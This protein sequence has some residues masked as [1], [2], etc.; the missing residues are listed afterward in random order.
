MAGSFVYFNVEMNSDDLMT[1]RTP[2][3][4]TGLKARKQGLANIV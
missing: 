1:D 2:P 3:H 4:I